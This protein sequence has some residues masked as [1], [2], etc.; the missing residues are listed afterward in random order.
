MSEADLTAERFIERLRAVQSDAELAKIQRYFKAGAGEYGEGDTFLGVRM[1]DV[2][3]LA[4]EFIDAAAG[5]DR[6]VAG[7]RSP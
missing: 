1:G 7:E 5:R 2:F 4:K 3:A 6:A